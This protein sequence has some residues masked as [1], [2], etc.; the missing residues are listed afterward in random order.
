[1]R[2]PATKSLPTIFG[3]RGFIKY[4]LECNAGVKENR[5]ENVITVLIEHKSFVN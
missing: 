1:M 4:I 3:D 2:Y 5:V